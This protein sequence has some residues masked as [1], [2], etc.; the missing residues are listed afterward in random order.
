MTTDTRPVRRRDDL[1]SV[2]RQLVQSHS[3]IAVP[4]ADIFG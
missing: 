2:A 1:P 4:N 3:S